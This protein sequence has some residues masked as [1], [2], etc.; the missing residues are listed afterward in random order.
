MA[1]QKNTGTK[2]PIQQAQG[3]VA[4]KPLL[5][6]GKSISN[7]LGLSI[8]LEEIG[9]APLLRNAL[10]FGFVTIAAFVIW[11]QFA[12]ID[13]V[14]V[15]SGEVVPTG[16]VQILQHI[17]GGTISAIDVSEGE[18]VKKGQVL[19]RLDPTDLIAEINQTTTQ[20]VI[21]KMKIARLDAFTE[22]KEMAFTLLDKRF[23]PFLDEQRELLEAQRLDLKNQRAILVSQIEQRKSEKSLL[24]NQQA[25]LAKQIAPLQEQLN[26]RKGLMKKRTLSRFDYLQSEREFLKEQGSLEELALKAV[27]VNQSIAEARGRLAEVVDHSVRTALDEMAATNAE[28]AEKEE[29][30]SKLRSKLRRLDIYA[31]VDGI[32]QG[33]D[34]K[35]IGSVIAPGST[36]VSVVPIGQELILEVHIRT[37]DIGHIEDGQKATVKFATYNYAR[38]GSVDGKLTHISA[39]TFQDEK[40]IN[41]YKGKVQL[42][43]SFVGDNPKR[44]FILPGMTAT[45]DIHSGQKTV[46][47]YLLKPIHTT[48]GQSFRER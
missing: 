26:I 38:Y 43:Q 9:P 39:T 34:V 5:D 6:K 12:E 7:R 22:N 4:Q 11:A 32:I 25:I 2:A 40:G 36:I 37:E 48:L 23:Q 16:A 17:D 8:M 13:E 18:I 33:L 1:D 46:M 42:A 44:N 19:V 24:T 29:R 35:S 30:L 45:A 27:S 20:L 15:A 28:A 21:L 41:Y 3:E 47:E 31:P 14:S 10:I